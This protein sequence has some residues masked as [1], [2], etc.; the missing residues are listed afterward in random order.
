MSPTCHSFWPGHWERIKCSWGW[1][2]LLNLWMCIYQPRIDIG[3]STLTIWLP[4]SLKRNLK[5][6]DDDLVKNKGAPR[7][8]SFLGLFIWSYCFMFLLLLAL[9]CFE[10]KIPGLLLL[11]LC[12]DQIQY[13]SKQA[14][15]DLASFLVALKNSTISSMYITCVKVGPLA[16]SLTPLI[17]PVQ[18][19]LLSILER[20][21]CPKINGYEDRGLPYLKPLLDLN[22]SDL[23]PLTSTSKETDEIQAT[24]QL[25]KTLLNPML[26]ST[27]WINFQ[28]ILS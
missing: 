7:Y 28:L 23:P 17:L 21:S 26:V 16:L 4:A 3:F 12:P 2:G 14:T 13:L 1:L 22:W 10:K 24:I 25:I 5:S 19:S 6:F 15:R 9:E 18:S 8:T 20:T 27:A 11:M